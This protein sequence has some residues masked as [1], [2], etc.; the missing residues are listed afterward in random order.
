MEYWP[1]GIIEK[2]KSPSNQGMCFSQGL[3]K[4]IVYPQI[5]YKSPFF[6]WCKLPKTWDFHEFP[7]MF[8]PIPFPVFV[9]EI[10]LFMLHSNSF[11]CCSS[12]LG[13][14]NGYPILHFF[15]KNPCPGNSRQV[16]CSSGMLRKFLKIASRQNHHN[17]SS[18]P[19]PLTLHRYLC[20]KTNRFVD[21]QIRHFF[22]C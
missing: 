13:P 21:G 5:K 15:R 12:F 11:N 4:P 14:S 20:L 6:P 2:Q 9:G 22:R 7:P 8:G 19:Y 10:N 3:S 17:P 1:F 16:A 18:F